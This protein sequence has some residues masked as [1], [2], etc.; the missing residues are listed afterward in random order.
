MRRMNRR[1]KRW[2]SGTG[3]SVGYIDYLIRRGGDAAGL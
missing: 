3:M 2:G 1:E